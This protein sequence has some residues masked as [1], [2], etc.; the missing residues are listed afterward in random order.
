MS[1]DK[2]PRRAPGIASRKIGEETVLVSP[3]TGKVFVLNETGGLI[4]EMCDG[5]R[6]VDQV[7][8]HLAAEFGIL[9]EQAGEDVLGLIQ[10][11]AKRGLVE[12]V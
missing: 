5:E 2:K 12:M 11:L 9:P 1:A 7:A 8:A 10:E 6:S 3:K 4:W